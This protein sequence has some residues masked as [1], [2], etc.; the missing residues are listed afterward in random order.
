MGFEGQDS[1]LIALDWQTGQTVWQTPRPVP[2]SWS[3]PTVVS[4]DGQYRILTA[5]SPFVIVYDA[6]TGQELYRVDCMYGD[7]AST[8]VIADK[9]L[10]VI[11]PY[12]KLVAVNADESQP[13]DDPQARI[14]WEVSSQ[15]PDI[16][17]PVT[18]GRVIWT[19]T[20]PGNLSG[21]DITDGRELYTQSLKLSFQASPTLVGQTLYLLSEKGIM[22]IADTGDAYNELHRSELGEKCFATPAFQPGRIYI[23]GEKNLYAI[24]S[25]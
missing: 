20:T 11:E 7:I 6:K 8:P 17:S 13:F 23:R 9:T 15:M 25:R 1:K 16:C 10:F 18:D 3:S 2:N 21:F 24:G 4:I 12:N 19:L 22:V 14:L 5:A